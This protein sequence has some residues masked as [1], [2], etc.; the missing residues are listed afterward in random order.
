MKEPATSP[1]ESR[2][3]MERWLYVRTFAQMLAKRLRQDALLQ[4]AGALAYNTLF[5][6][7]PTLVL[8]LLVLSI[9]SGPAV[10]ATPASTAPATAPAAGPAAATASALDT[11]VAT[12]RRM[13]RRA[14][15]EESTLGERVQEWILTQ[16]GLH[17]LAIEDPQSPG[18][19]ISVET[20]LQQRIVKVRELVQSPGT[21]L[22]AFAALLYGVLSLM[23]VVELTFNAIY[24]SPHAR[25]WA[26]RFAL[27]T[28]LF[29]WGPLC[30]GASIALSQYLLTGVHL[31]HWA[32]RP[33]SVVG[34]FLVSWLLL[35]LCYRLIPSTL[36]R[37]RSALVGAAFGA[38][39]WELG[40]Y[41]FGLYV[42]Y[43]VGTRNWYGSI[44]L[45]PLFM[46]WIF[47]TWNF[48]LL[49]LQIAYV[50]QYYSA[51]RRQRR[52]SEHSDF[53]L[54]DLDWVLP[55]GV[56]LYRWFVRG[57]PLTAELAAEEIG[58]PLDVAEHLLAA[59]RR[60]GL[61]HRVEAADEAYALSRP[62]PSI[63]GEDLLAAARALCIPLVDASSDAVNAAP[64][65]R[66]FRQLEH[67]WLSAA[68]L[69]RL[70][71]D[72]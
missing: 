63:T 1:A 61:V 12:T 9:M 27:Y 48:V 62:P 4:Q 35:V 8:A 38:L 3:W 51:L 26:H 60:A 29:F 65:L 52:F 31:Q 47:L 16:F 17:G 42:Q 67:D 6:L 36:V 7:L 50:H 24:R 5:S 58:M 45:V 40:K 13:A 30:I 2:R 57:R 71:G 44:A 70:A 11:D 25:R 54:A 22:I 15:A 20:F 59:L 21:G 46:F 41:A 19:R 39:L 56:L 14:R 43:S 64:G 53:P 37:L 72:S 66:E 33:L 34:S 32:R 69:P 10:P 55:L 28:A 18:S 23:R 49:G 68:T